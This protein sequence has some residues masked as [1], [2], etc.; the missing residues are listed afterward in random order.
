MAITQITPAQIIGGWGGGGSGGIPPGTPITNGD[1]I[2][3]ELIFD[4]LGDVVTA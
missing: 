2:T 1:P 3:P 4:S